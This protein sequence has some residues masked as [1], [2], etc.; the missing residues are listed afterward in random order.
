MAFRLL[1]HILPP[2]SPTLETN[3]IVE[4]TTINWE[5]SGV[6]SPLIGNYHLTEWLMT[7]L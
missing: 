6:S 1:Q 2:H 4:S 3:F 5:G 7:L